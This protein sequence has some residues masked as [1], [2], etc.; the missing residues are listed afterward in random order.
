MPHRKRKVR[1]QRG[2]RTHGYGR[3]G[4]H[5]GGG[6]RGGKGKAGMHKHK[7]SYVLRFEPDYF[8]KRG[9]KS[10]RHKEASTINVGELSELVSR[11]LKEKKALERRDGIHIDLEELGYDKL[12]GSGQA[13]C[14]LIVT[15]ASY[16][17]TALRKIDRAKGRILRTK[18]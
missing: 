12:L 4:Q 7:W 6:Q 9:F 13:S 10:A 11:L 15:V 8:R 2:S 17:E 18:H 16:S 5:R 14:P 3:V 1:K